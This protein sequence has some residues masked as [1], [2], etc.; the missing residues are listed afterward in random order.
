[1]AACLGRGLKSIPWKMG[2]ML[3]RVLAIC[4]IVCFFYPSLWAR[5]RQSVKRYNNLLADIFPRSQ[6][7]VG[8]TFCN[9][10]ASVQYLLGRQSSGA[11][12]RDNNGLLPIHLA[13]IKGHVDVVRALLQYWP[14]LRELLNCHGQNI[15][16]VAAKS[17]GQNMVS[18]GD[19]I[20]DWRLKK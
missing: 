9:S 17:R 7:S 5:S 19:G 20:E 3:R 16:H 14:D 18:N 11:I 2:V 10:C 4:G 12:A 15:L 6:R 8:V 13:S 1:M